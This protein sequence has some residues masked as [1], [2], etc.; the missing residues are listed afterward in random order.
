MFVFRKKNKASKKIDQLL[1]LIE[2]DPNNAKNRLRLADV[3][4]REGD[5]KSAIREYRTAAKHLS[6]EGFNLKAISIYKKI[7]ALDGMS[8]SDHKSLA[9]LYTEEGLLAEAGRTYERI[10]Q[11][12][13]QDQDAHE[14]L[15]EIATSGEI[16]DESE[17]QAT[18]SSGAVPIEALLAPSQDEE[19]RP[20]PSSDLLGQTLDGMDIVDPSDEGNPGGE[21]RELG[22]ERGIGTEPER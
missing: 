6:G 22:S 15:R 20:D 13:P 5:K 10:L 17:N 16:R 19:T 3:Y 1:G 21:G 9:S 11:I 12:K 2:K 14:A 18:D 7:F 8:L 4:A